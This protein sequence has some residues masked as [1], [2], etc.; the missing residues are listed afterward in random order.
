MFDSEFQLN[1]FLKWENLSPLNVIL[2][3]QSRP[4]S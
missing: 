1:K 4:S 3:D 2:I